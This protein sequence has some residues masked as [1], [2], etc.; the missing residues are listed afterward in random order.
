MKTQRQA[1]CSLQS[2][3]RVTLFK[4]FRN[5]PIVLIATLG[6]GGFPAGVFAGGDVD[7]ERETD[8]VP[9]S[10]HDTTLYANI[11]V[12]ANMEYNTVYVKLPESVIPDDDGNPSTTDHQL[13]GKIGWNGTPPEGWSMEVRR[14]DVPDLGWTL[15]FRRDRN[16]DVNVTFRICVLG[17]GDKDPQAFTNP[18]HAIK[19]QAG[20][21]CEGGDGNGITLDL[22]R[23]GR[24]GEPTVRNDDA[25]A[26]DPPED[27]RYFKITTD[28]VCRRNP[29]N[30]VCVPLE[31]DDIGEITANGENG[32]PDGWSHEVVERPA[33]SGN[34]FLCFFRADNVTSNVTFKICIGPN[35][36]GDTARICGHGGWSYGRR[37][38]DGEDEEARSGTGARRIT[39]VSSTV[40][41]FGAG[42]G[43]AIP[44]EVVSVPL[45]LDT[46]MPIHGWSA[47]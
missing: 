35:G 42:F 3:P 27:A 8:D 28:E 20:N 13:K 45:T 30:R 37:N 39:T 21:T 38:E 14:V 17:D 7:I 6:L 29:I 36:D 1:V 15:C 11:K 16:T 10:S 33:D 41:G 24:L 2:E 5:L 19:D 32:I 43:F 23:R 26:D 47:A 25:V 9:A 44:G 34:W 4:Y 18:E 31:D 46:P 12:E 22:D 40:P